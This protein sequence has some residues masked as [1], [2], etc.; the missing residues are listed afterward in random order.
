MTVLEVQDGAFQDL[1][2]PATWREVRRRLMHQRVGGYVADL[3]QTR[4]PVE[5]YE[6]TLKDLF[7]REVEWIAAQS[8][9][10]AKN[11]QALQRPLDGMRRVGDRGSPMASAVGKGPL[12]AESG[13]AQRSAD[14]PP[15]EPTPGVEER[16]DP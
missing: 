10:A 6:D 2:G 15:Q 12:G 8:E 11:P 4:Y 5:V 16:Q 7:R 13:A 1:E 3:R 14:A 9:K